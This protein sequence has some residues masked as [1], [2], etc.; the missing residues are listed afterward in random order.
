VERA[1]LYWPVPGG[2]KLRYT[3]VWDYPGWLNA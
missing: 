2:T 3:T 1:A